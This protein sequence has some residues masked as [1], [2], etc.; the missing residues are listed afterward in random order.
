[1]I[2][3]SDKENMKKLIELEKISLTSTLEIQKNLNKQ[4]LMFIKNFIPI[5]TM[6]KIN[7]DISIEKKE[8][9]TPIAPIIIIGP[10]M[11][12]TK[13]FEIKK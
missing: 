12:L 11:I 9:I 7:L 6:N 2:N 10:I 1:M 3:F 13:R 4:I 5:K 8:V